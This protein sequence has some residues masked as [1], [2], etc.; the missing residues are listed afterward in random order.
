M[1]NLYGKRY[2]KLDNILNL[3]YKVIISK[4]KKILWCTI[5][6]GVKE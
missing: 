1:S 6:N 3:K 5:I 4:D 2:K